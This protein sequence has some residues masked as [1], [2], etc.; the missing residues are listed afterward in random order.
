VRESWVQSLTFL[1]ALMGAERL[2]SLFPGGLVPP[3]LADAPSELA[4]RLPD[5]Y[6]AGALPTWLSELL[7]AEANDELDRASVERG[8]LHRVMP[9]TFWT[10]SVAS[11]TPSGSPP[12]LRCLLHPTAEHVVDV[13]GG[14]SGVTRDSVLRAYDEI[15]VLSDVIDVTRRLRALN[16][17]LAKAFRSA[18]MIPCTAVWNS[19]VFATRHWRPWAIYLRDEWGIDL[20]DPLPQQPRREEAQ[21]LDYRL[22]TVA[23]AQV[24]TAQ[25]MFLAIEVAFSN[26]QSM[27]PCQDAIEALE[28]VSRAEW[29]S[30][31]RS[32]SG[33]LLEDQRLAASIGLAAKVLARVS[34]GHSG[35]ST[36]TGGRVGADLD[37]A[38]HILGHT[39][40]SLPCSRAHDD[41]LIGEMLLLLWDALPSMSEAA[42]CTGAV[43]PDVENRL[44]RLVDQLTYRIRKQAPTDREQSL[45]FEGAASSG[46]IPGELEQWQV[47][48]ESQ[49]RIRQIMAAAE[50]LTPLQR[51][52]LELYASGLSFPDIAPELGKAEGTV[53]SH[54]SRA[55]DKI[56]RRVADPDDSTKRVS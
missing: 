5:L 41:Y 47:L 34:L 51:Q 7:S 11:L 23:R 33:A 8:E 49:A 15:R 28:H 9:P 19:H 32:M 46:D 17:D 36:E 38:I 44:H 55:I 48:E 2:S 25:D 40:R 4:R 12:T 31:V 43:P 14:E 29:M 54:W 3:R 18:F 6:Q 10:R 20:D 16:H 42:T 27:N 13:S 30:N 45:S 21:E 56:R 35:V 26:S 52:V 22:L 24:T 37:K 39:D 1:K 53:K 50:H